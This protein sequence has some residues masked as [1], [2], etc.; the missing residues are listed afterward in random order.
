MNQLSLEQLEKDYIGKRNGTLVVQSIRTERR[1]NRNYYELSC[2]CDCGEVHRI[3]KTHFDSRRNLTCK[4]CLKKRRSENQIPN[5]VNM[6]FGRLRVI[7]QI[8]RKLTKHVTWHCACD[9]GNTTNVTTSDLMS[10]HVQSCRCLQKESTSKHNTKNW[11]GVVSK[12]G[13]EIKTPAFI[14]D[15]GSWVWNCV[16]PLCGEEFTALP[17]KIMSGHIKSCGCGKA[18][19]GIR[20]DLTGTTIGY[21]TCLYPIPEKG[22]QTRWM[23]RCVCG[24]EYSVS[25]SVLYNEKNPSCGCIR[26][27]KNSAF[28]EQ[29]LKDNGCTFEKEYRFEDCVNQRALPFDFALLKGHTVDAV[30]EVQ[31]AQHYHPVDSFGGKEGFAYRQ[32]NDK[33]KRDYCKEKDIFLL[34]LPYTLTKQEIKE[35]VLNAIYRNDCDGAIGNNST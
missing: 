19:S 6:R 25:I 22:K 29:L 26:E 27:S 13:V 10:G 17:C 5:L 12:A 9:C 3:E 28:V 1:K 8:E 16:C 33:I 24:K 4:S 11:A 7:E 31:G 34:E 20:R 15:K 23:C 14:N 18:R 35:K 30:I 32:K 2:L 21:L